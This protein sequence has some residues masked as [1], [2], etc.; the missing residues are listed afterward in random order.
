MSCKTDKPTVSIIIPCKNEGSNLAMT[1]DSI[2]AASESTAY[3]IIVVDDGSSDGCCNFLLQGDRYRAVSLITT[4]GLGAAAARNL[5]AAAAQGMYLVF[6]DAHVQV[7]ARWLSKL[8]DTFKHAGVDAVSPAIGSL[9]NPA[10][11]GYGQTWNERLKTVWLPRPPGATVKAV[12]LLPGGCLAVRAAA[13]HKVA[14]FDRGFISWGW[15]DVELSLKLWLFGFRLY[16]NPA[17]KI[18]HF[19]RIRH[20]YRVTTYQVSYNLLRLAVSHFNHKRL[21]K[22]LS[23]VRSTTPS[24]EIFCHVLTAGGL[25]QRLDYL[26]H[27]I[28]DDDWFMER[29]H[30]NF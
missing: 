27:R 14:G 28:Y 15:E 18:L 16:V 24:K 10:A 8:L 22:V 26:Q 25:K 17:V 3:E 20:P 11:V 19:F 5:G 7:P 23:L 4:T 21:V 1:V 2:L 9:K 13:F 30:I 6:C 29:F 12:P